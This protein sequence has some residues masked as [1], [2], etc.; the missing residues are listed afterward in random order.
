MNIYSKSPYKSTNV[1]LVLFVCLVINGCSKKSGLKA[2]LDTEVDTYLSQ[3]NP[4]GMAIS[5]FKDQNELWS[6]AQGY[7]DIEKKIPL[8]QR[9]S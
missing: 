5:V 1:I 8:V 6:Y 7:A 9:L 2:I 4:P 3:Y